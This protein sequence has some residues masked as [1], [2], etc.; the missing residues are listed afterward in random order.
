MR[1]FA[2]VLPLMLLGMPTRSF[3]CGPEVEIHFQEAS[4]DQFR[5][6]FTRGARLSLERL[7][8]RLAGQRRSEFVP[9]DERFVPDIDIDAGRVTVVMP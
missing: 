4:P 2:V 6:S 9:F 7:E 8:I 5:I 1:W 3:A